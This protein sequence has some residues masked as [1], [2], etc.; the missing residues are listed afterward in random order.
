MGVGRSLRVEQI[1]A[2]L[3]LTHTCE[4]K[5]NE[6]ILNWLNSPFRAGL[7]ALLCP[8]GAEGWFV[9]HRAV[10]SLCTDLLG[11][12]PRCDCEIAPHTACASC[13]RSS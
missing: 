2:A 9:F 3:G 5:N 6:C 11:Q 12:Q 8:G 10:F 4:T 7:S 1:P 13:C